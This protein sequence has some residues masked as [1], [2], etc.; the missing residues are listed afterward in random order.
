MDDDA[1]APSEPGGPGSS[2][3]VERTLFGADTGAE[4]QSKKHSYSGTSDM[5]GSSSSPNPPINLQTPDQEKPPSYSHSHI[6]PKHGLKSTLSPV[7][8]V[9]KPLTPPLEFT[10]IV[11]VLRLWRSKGHEQPLR[12]DIA[13]AI[14]TR[15]REVYAKA[16]TDSFAKYTSKAQKLGLIK[17]GGGV[18]TAWISLQPAYC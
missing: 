11:E 15:D 14:V 10:T 13:L 3:A 4:G 7:E 6:P 8:G 16:G 5:R 18:S 2:D 9:S 1:K 17:L 12:S